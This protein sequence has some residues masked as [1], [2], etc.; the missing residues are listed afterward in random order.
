MHVFQQQ[1]LPIVDSKINL[2]FNDGSYKTN[3]TP[4]I[5]K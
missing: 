3:S 4:N 2:Q 1:Q 5:I